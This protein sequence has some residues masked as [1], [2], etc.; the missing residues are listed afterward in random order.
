MMLMSEDTAVRLTLAI[1]GA[2]LSGL[3]TAVSFGVYTRFN[4]ARLEEKIDK[5]FETQQKNLNGIGS[6]VTA[7]EKDAA[8]RYH[9]LSMALMLA[10]PTEQEE[11]LTHLMKEDS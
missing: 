7:N 10:V 1:G 2:A 9:N 6:K 4:F 3:I 11:K 5:N 8:R